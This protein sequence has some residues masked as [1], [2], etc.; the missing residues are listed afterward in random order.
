LTLI[1]NP[2]NKIWN[3]VVVD[4]VVVEP[5]KVFNKKAISN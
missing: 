5:M 4:L 2:I 1:I 3:L